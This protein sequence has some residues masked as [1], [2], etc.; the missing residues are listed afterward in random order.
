MRS[1]MVAFA[2]YVVVIVGGLAWFAL[3]GLGRL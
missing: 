2:V 3:A 1:Q